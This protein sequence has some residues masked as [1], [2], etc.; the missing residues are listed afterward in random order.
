MNK[1]N[2]APLVLV[3]TLDLIGLVGDIEGRG[4]VETEWGGDN[5]ELH[6]DR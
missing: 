2:N 3:E 1:L 4:S 5:F 6:C